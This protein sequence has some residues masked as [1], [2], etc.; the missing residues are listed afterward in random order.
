[1]QRMEYKYKKANRMLEVQR[2]DL[3]QERMVIESN[4]SRNVCKIGSTLKRIEGIREEKNK[5]ARD[6][7]TVAKR[8]T[9]E[10][11]CVEDRFLFEKEVYPS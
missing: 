8:L 1:V 7:R 6:V 10:K 2:G 5:L 3:D 11:E 4:I 9:Y